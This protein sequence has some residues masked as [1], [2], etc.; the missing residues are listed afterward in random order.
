M[1]GLRVACVTSLLLTACSYGSAPFREFE[2]CQD[3]SLPSR[4]D[5]RKIW[6]E[7]LDSL[8][9]C[10]RWAE[11]ARLAG[12]LAELEGTLPW[13]C[14]RLAGTASLPAGVCSRQARSRRQP[15]GRPPPREAT[16]VV[17]G[18]RSRGTCVGWPEPR[19]EAR[20]RSIA[21]WVSRS[22]LKVLLRLSRPT[23]LHCGLAEPSDARPERLYLDLR[24]RRAPD[25]RVL[26]RCVG[27]PVARV[28]VGRHRRS[29]RVVFELRR[30]V[31]FHVHPTPK[32]TGLVVD[33]RLVGT[34]P[35]GPA[36]V[37]ALDAGHGGQS[38]G[39][40]GPGGL[41]EKDLALAVAL[42][43]GRIL[44]E[45]GIRV[46]LTRK[47]D[48]DL[49][50]DERTGIALA[51]GADLFVSVHFNAEPTRRRQA[52]ETYVLDVASDEFARRLAD[53]E[54]GVAGGEVSSLR[55]AAARV[56]EK[57]LAVRSRRLAQ[58]IQTSVYETVRKWLPEA[59]DGGV[60][61]ALFYVLLTARVP[62]A[63]VEIAYLSHPKVTGVVGTQVFQQE[64]AR[65]LATGVLRYLREQGYRLGAG[66][67]FPGAFRF[68]ATNSAR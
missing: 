26:A 60:R 31:V 23:R 56:A 37:V 9:T 40:V 24:L 11:A 1:T 65:A 15:P 16:D 38:L 63:L 42:E 33:L 39:A 17:S 30:S 8:E 54:N 59:R 66:G 7:R 2:P 52:V 64:V 41:H 19:G 25:R 13:D 29:W 34:K 14:W 50:L 61:K 12:R 21:C 22:R 49:G 58:A 3:A 53:R 45:R 27:G 4:S 28:R 51:T 36:P 47:R 5:P 20:V 68:S 18:L 57:R 10:G 55:L 48:V 44:E 67:R 62:A 32:E 35:P 46:V 6:Y 43:A